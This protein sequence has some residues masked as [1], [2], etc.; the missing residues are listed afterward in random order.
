MVDSGD[1]GFEVEDGLTSG[2]DVELLAGF[3]LVGGEPV[4]IGVEGD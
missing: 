2:S 4:A 3:E 1:G